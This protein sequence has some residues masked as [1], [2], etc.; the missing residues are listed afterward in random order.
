MEIELLR[1][2][3]CLTKTHPLVWYE[4]SIT[5]DLSLGTRH[6]PDLGIK[7]MRVSVGKSNRTK[8]RQHKQNMSS[9]MVQS[10]FVSEPLVRYFPTQAC[11]DEC[12]VVWSKIENTACVHGVRRSPQCGG[13]CRRALADHKLCPHATVFCSMC[14]QSRWPEH[15][16]YCFGDRID[17]RTG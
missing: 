10:S 14:G 8:I 7:H 11:G 9:R 6:T 12:K 3:F 15:S 16:C 17:K 1:M 4:G 5:H 2:S 13:D